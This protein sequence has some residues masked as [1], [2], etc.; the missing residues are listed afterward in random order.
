MQSIKHH[1]LPHGLLRGRAKNT[2]DSI[3]LLNPLGQPILR[4]RITFTNQPKPVLDFSQFAQGHAKL[5]HKLP[6]RLSRLRFFN[7]GSYSRSG[8]KYLPARHETR[9][10]LRHGVRRLHDPNRK[11]ES[12]LLDTYDPSGRL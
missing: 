6:L 4:Y 7:M 3:R 11:L 12:S 1:S 9:R 8:S 5:T 10:S 2:S